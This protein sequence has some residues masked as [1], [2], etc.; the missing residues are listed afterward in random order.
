M[1]GD[2]AGKQGPNG[3][4]TG[5]NPDEAVRT[6]AVVG[7]I[8]A[9]WQPQS[10]EVKTLRA[11]CEVAREAP[12]RLNP[13]LAP[14]LWGFEV[15]DIG[16][17]L[18]EQF[19]V[20]SAREWTK[21]D[22]KDRARP[23]MRYYWNTLLATWTEKYLTIADAL[24]RDGIALRPGLAFLQG[25]GTGHK[26]RYGFVFTP[27]SATPAGTAPVEPDLLQVP[28]VR[29]R[30][31]DISG[32]RLLRW[33]AT[34]GLFLGGWGGRLFVGTG[35]LLTVLLIL[36]LWFLFLAATAASAAVVILQLALSAGISLGIGYALLGWLARLINNR[37][38][39]APL[40]LQ[41][42]S[43]HDDYLLEL[44]RLPGA[45]R[46]TLYLVRYAADCP[47]CGDDGRDQIQVAPG[48]LEFFG[49]LVGRCHR[50]PN[51]HVFSFDH[52]TKRGRFL[53]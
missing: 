7:R 2:A 37:V 47:L 1:P 45:S 40:Y 6:V 15:L 29:Y 18:A 5:W 44:R 43:G 31:Q 20:S 33:L 36:S 23:R 35:T 32:T 19:I 26:N 53:R 34:R 38:T 39:R 4:E 16:P 9:G 8:A 49:R 12:D 21:S 10:V 14:D 24:E 48:R 3:L 52:I 41:P 51:A 11:L 30:P 27:P 50:A 17:C 22:G 28:L 13:N 46:N 25:V 42:W